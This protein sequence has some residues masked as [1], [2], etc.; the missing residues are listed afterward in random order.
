MAMPAVYTGHTVVPD[1]NFLAMSEK[2]YWRDTFY[3][4][5]DHITKDYSEV[6]ETYPEIPASMVFGLGDLEVK[7][8]E[9]IKE[10]PSLTK[11]IN[12][13]YQTEQSKS[14]K[15]IATCIRFFIKFFYLIST[16]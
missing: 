10:K 11:L 14:D 3:L 9:P 13:D 16:I 6:A 2:D 4:P 8:P 1:V 5:N 12:G 7:K 15:T